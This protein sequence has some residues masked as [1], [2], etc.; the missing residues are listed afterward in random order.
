VNISAKTKI[1][2][3]IF[4][5]VNLGSRY[6]GFMKKTR[7]RISHATVPLNKEKEP[8]CTM[9]KGGGGCL[10]QLVFNEI[11][12]LQVTACFGQEEN[13]R[14]GKVRDV[15]GSQGNVPLLAQTSAHIHPTH[16]PLFI[17]YS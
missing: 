11:R 12:V 3:K 13:K 16:I 7:L 8:E 2:S 4:K 14:I 10:P 9:G 6:Y 5:G 1:F 17:P 15:G